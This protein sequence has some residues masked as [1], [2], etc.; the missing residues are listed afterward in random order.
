MILIIGQIVISLVL[1]FLVLIQERSA[2]LSILFGG[3]GGTP[4]QTRRGME[5][6]IFWATIVSAVIF[7]ILAVIH[8]VVQI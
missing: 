5:K 6:F 2:G 7:A 3:A 1:I 8:L 4:Y